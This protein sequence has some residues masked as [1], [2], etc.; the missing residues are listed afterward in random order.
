MFW[1]E[2]DETGVAIGKGNSKQWSSN[3][4]L[5]TRSVWGGVGWVGYAKSG[6]ILA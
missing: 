4:Y 2:L 5:V 6:N 1:A 3:A